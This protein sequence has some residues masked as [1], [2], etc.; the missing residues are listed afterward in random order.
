M[1]KTSNA[2]SEH[3]KN[4]CVI[5]QAWLHSSSLTLDDPTKYLSTSSEGEKA[6]C[7]EDI[8]KCS[9]WLLQQ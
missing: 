5:T 3:V 8:W 6:L 1:C 4:A 9:S 2:S 7:R